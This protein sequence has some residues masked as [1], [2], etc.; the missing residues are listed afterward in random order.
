MQR[1][2]D[3]AIFLA[4]VS[5]ERIVITADLGFGAIAHRSGMRGTSTIIVRMT[6]PDHR[7]VTGRLQPLL[8]GNEQHL[9]RGAIMVI[10]DA[11]YRIRRLDEAAEF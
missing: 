9:A 6:R 2:D 1:A 10:E 11:R 4:A 3:D 5:E 7:T 8:D